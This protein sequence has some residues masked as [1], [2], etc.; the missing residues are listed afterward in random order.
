MFI[1]HYITYWPSKGVEVEFA[2][3]VVARVALILR[4]LFA[5]GRQWQVVRVENF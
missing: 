1:G 2:I 4:S 5:L 3:G